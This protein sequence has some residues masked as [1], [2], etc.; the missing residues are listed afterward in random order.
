M[1]ADPPKKKPKKLVAV[2]KSEKCKTMKR[3][4]KMEK[5]V[6]LKERDSTV[7][8]LKCFPKIHPTCIRLESIQDCFWDKIFIEK[9]F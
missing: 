7:T 5:K 3:R 2:S 1:K 4:V 9:L 8:R 6:Y